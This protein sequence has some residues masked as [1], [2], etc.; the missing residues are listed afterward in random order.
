MPFVG[1]NNHMIL[2]IIINNL[3]RKYIKLE[4]IGPLI[5]MLHHW[6]VA[7]EGFNNMLSK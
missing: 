4:T 3:M 1:I 6:V 2:Q 7:Q 5:M